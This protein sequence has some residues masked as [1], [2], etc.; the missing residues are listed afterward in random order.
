MS[1]EPKMASA[2]IDSTGNGGWER[3]LRPPNLAG[4]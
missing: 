3:S 2:A 4:F 1:H